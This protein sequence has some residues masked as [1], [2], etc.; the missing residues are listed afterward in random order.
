MA[1]GSCHLFALSAAS[2]PSK[3]DSNVMMAIKAC[4]EGDPGSTTVIRTADNAPFCDF[5]VLLKTTQGAAV[6]LVEATISTLMKHMHST[7]KSAPDVESPAPGGG[8]RSAQ[9]NIPTQRVQ[10]PN[11][12][13]LRALQILEGALPL[14]RTIL[15]GALPLA[16]TCY[17]NAPLPFVRPPPRL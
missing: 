5:V 1:K 14:A 15:K 17:L 8:S 4:L 6:L 13:A 9:G 3:V 7:G 10:Q 12:R 16:R 11:M 2:V